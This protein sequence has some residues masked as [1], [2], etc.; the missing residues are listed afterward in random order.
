MRLEEHERGTTSSRCNRDDSLCSFFFSSS[1]HGG[2]NEL[3]IFSPPLFSFFLS[4][5]FAWYVNRQAAFFCRFSID[6]PTTD[7]RSGNDFEVV[8]GQQLRTY[9]FIFVGIKFRTTFFFFFFLRSF[10]PGGILSV[11]FPHFH[12]TS[13]FNGPFPALI[14]FRG[15]SPLLARVLRIFRT[16]STEHG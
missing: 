1:F 7:D 2:Q 16:R 5:F 6:D 12:G 3:A 11:P 14:K 15:R 4:F 13:F 10:P 8:S 9:A